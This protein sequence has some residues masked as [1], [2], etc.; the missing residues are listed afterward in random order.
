MDISAQVCKSKD[1]GFSKSVR[2]SVPKPIRLTL[3][4]VPQISYDELVKNALIGVVRSVLVQ[5]AEEGLPGNHHFY[6][7]FDTNHPGVRIPND[8][9]AKYP[10]DMV[11]VLQNKF[12]DLAVDEE[13]FSVTLRFGGLPRHLYVPFSSVITFSDPSVQFGL[14]LK[15]GEQEESA[16]EEDQPAPITADPALEPEIVEKADDEEEA[17][18]FAED[19]TEP[20]SESDSND[21]NVVQLDVFRKK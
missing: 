14:S 3:M 1:I 4:T 19:E 2:A 13:G 15:F 6:I 12:W 5:T 10:T 8:L 16:A 21:G 11:I 20:P 18:G 7:A 9:K 17:T